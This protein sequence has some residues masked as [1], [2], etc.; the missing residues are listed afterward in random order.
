[1]R[2]WLALLLLASCGVD[3]TPLHQALEAT[4]TELGE[5]L[6]AH[7]CI[8]AELGPFVTVTAST[9]SDFAGTSP[10]VNAV[11]T[12]FTVMLA[13]TGGTVKYRPARSGDWAVFSDPPGAVTVLDAAGNTLTSVLTHAVTACTGIPEV[14]VYP[15]VANA[16]YR[17]RFAPQQDQRAAVVL[18]HVPDFVTLYHPDADGDGA[19]ADTAST[20]VTACAPPPGWAVD[21]PSDCDDGRASAYPGAP[22]LCNDLDDDCDTMIDEG[23]VRPTFYPDADGDGAGI[24]GPTVEACVAPPGFAPVGGDC[25][26][27][28]P[29]VHPGADERCNMIDDD[30][31]GALDEPGAIDGDVLHRDEDA[32]GFGDPARWDRIC[33]A[34]AGYVELAGDCDDDDGDINPLADERCNGRDDDCDGLADECGACAP[35]FAAGPTC[36]SGG[37]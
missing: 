20:L 1:M 29:E 14:R 21:G 25:D 9:A 23:V 32:D 31:D 16:T 19:I 13:A 30:C 35:A 12:Y 18:E 36:S 22:E 5:P 6:I 11:H 26:D 4:C 24:A 2:S 15:L 8:H 34:P 33:G 7:T 3:D 37:S 27:T 17:L 28:T 10:N